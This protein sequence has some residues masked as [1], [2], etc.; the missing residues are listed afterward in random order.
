MTERRARLDDFLPEYH[1]RSA[2][3]TLVHADV[4]TTY[5][6]LSAASFTDSR[7]VRVLLRL[8]S[9]GR[10]LPPRPPDSS[11]LS[12]L[13]RGGFLQLA[14][15]PEQEMVFGIAGRF[16]LPRAERVTLESVGE[17]AEFQTPGYAKAAWNITLQAVTPQTTKLCTQ[18]RILCFGSDAKLR[19]RLYW[20]VVGPFSGLTRRALLAQ[21]KHAAERPQA[22]STPV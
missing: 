14:L 22:H 3:Q 12:D 8:R 13:K 2:H 7:L 6:A 17:F 16:W 10:P 1:V 5:R 21:V 18:T 15:E 11:F 20:G 19:F 4:A 9:L